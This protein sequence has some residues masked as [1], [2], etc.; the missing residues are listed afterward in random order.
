L[1]YMMRTR[2]RDGAP[3]DYVWPEDGAVF[4][5]SPIGIINTS[6]NVETARVF[7][8]FVLSAEGQRTMVELGDFIP[9]RADVQPPEG[10]PSLDE[11]N[12]IDI[13]WKDVNRRSQAIND[14]WTALFEG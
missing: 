8:D 10:A 5:P 2:V 4:I 9:I 6:D 11:I 14:A 13:D 3:V 7:V 12:A 1:D